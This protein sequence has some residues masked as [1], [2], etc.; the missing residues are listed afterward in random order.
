MGRDWSRP[1]RKLPATISIHSPRM[2]RDL[3]IIRQCPE[4]H[5]FNP[6]SPHGERPILAGLATASDDISIH[7]PRMGRDG[8]KRPDGS[9][10]HYFNPL[11]PHG[12]RRPHMPWPPPRWYFNPLS[13]HGERQHICT[14]IS[15]AFEFQSTLP[16]WGET[17]DK[18]HSRGCRSISIHSPR[19]GRD[20]YRLASIPVTVAFQSTL[21]AWG[22]TEK[23]LQ[24]VY[25]ALYFNPLSP[26]GERRRCFALTYHCRKFQ[27]TLPAWGETGGVCERLRAVKISI[28]SPR[29]GRDDDYD[30]QDCECDT[31]SIHSPRMGR[32]RYGLRFDARI[33]ISIHSPRMGRDD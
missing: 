29:M 33:T 28:H 2:G 19:M 30:W 7:S 31:I 6:L 4:H 13:P 10:Y 16:A 20:L 5:D 12:E 11:S 27:S 8:G 22:E 14:Y 24:K 9:L 21:P 23:P 17:T 32:D 18:G 25:R 15:R 3:F 26:H 1:Y